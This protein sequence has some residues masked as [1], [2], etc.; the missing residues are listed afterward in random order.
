MFLIDIQQDQVAPH[1]QLPRRARSSSPASDS[2]AARA[3]HR[4][5]RQR[6]EPGQLSGRPRPRVARPR[7]RHHLSRSPRVERTNHRT[8]S[9][10]RGRARW[11]PMR[12]C[13]KCRS[14]GAFTSASGSTSAIRCASTCSGGSLQ[15]RVTSV[16]EVKWEDS[17]RRRV[18]V[19]V[20]ARASGQGA[21]HLHR[22][23]CAHPRTQPHA[24]R[25]SATWS[26]S[27]RTSRRSTSA[28]SW[29]RSS[30]SSTT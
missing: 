6:R 27:F 19:R 12:R 4:R 16:R 14:S 17:R 13:S 7:V 18:H 15:A 25:S 30:P 29:P 1:A 23:F 10:G 20:P 22:Q 3:G 26:P 21:A 28:R 24:P 9:S 5:S 2:G 8:A 11:P